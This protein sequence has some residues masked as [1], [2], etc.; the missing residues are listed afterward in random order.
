MGI[1]ARSIIIMLSQGLTQVTTLALGIIL[2]RMVSKSTFGTYEQV[3]LVYLT[4][5][6]SISLQLHNSFYYFVPKLGPEQ[7]RT[8]LTQTFLVTLSIASIVS[9]I[10]LCGAG[11]IA[12]G[13]GNPDLAPLLRIFALYPF[14]ER[15]IILIP[16]FMIST[17]R[18]VRAGAY[19]LIAAVGRIGAVVLTCGLGYGLPTVMWAVVGVGAVVAAVGCADMARICPAGEWRIDRPLLRD[20]FNYAWPLLASTL[21]GVLNLQLNKILI[22]VSFEPGE[23]AVYSRG[24]MQL[25]VIALVTT[26]INTAMMPDLVVMMEQGKVRDALWTWQE[27]ARKC[28]LVIFP[29]FAFLF[30]VAQDLMIFVYGQDYA[31]AAWPF[32]VYLL[33]LPVRVAVYATL[34]RAAGRTKPVALAAL[35]SL[36]VN[37]CLGVTL[38]VLG[39]GGRLSFIG[40]MIGTVVATWV[41]WA[42]LLRRI[43]HITSVPFAR[44]MRWRELGAVFLTCLGCGAAVAV[45]PL[46]DWRLWVRL[47]VQ[48]T[49]F[50]IAFFAVMGGA[51]L[52]KRD[53]KR[54]LLW[55]VSLVRHCIQRLR[56]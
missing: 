21:V 1:R 48:G 3:N 34:F 6:T 4:L 50:V 45:L 19:S 8:L 35:L 2:V 13:F 14:A 32:R 16:A 29:C 20:Q 42:Y 30:V 22:S 49:L 15:L 31:Q 47:L 54:M 26:S 9:L 40:P 23:F 41:S 56:G 28:S 17:D 46:P 53:E 44:V 18:P 38:V 7:H 5:A 10:M 37:V 33:S 27:G 24:A 36:T 11:A 39:K 25:P 51:G 52:L 43:T 55:P 12:R